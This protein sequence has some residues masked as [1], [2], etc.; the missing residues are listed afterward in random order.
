MH[1]EFINILPREPDK[2]KPFY[3]S[4]K[5]RLDSFTKD[6]E[7]GKYALSKINDASQR[8]HQINM[9]GTMFLRL[10]LITYNPSQ[11][12]TITKQFIAS[13]LHKVSVDDKGRNKNSSYKCITNFY[14]NVFKNCFPRNYK[15]P[16]SKGLHNTI[17]Y[18]ATDIL[19]NYQQNVKSNFISYAHEYVD[20]LLGFTQYIKDN[21]DQLSE[22]NK[23]YWKKIKTGIVNDL[24]KMSPGELE[25]DEKYHEWIRRHRS[26]I[27][28]ESYNK[29]HQKEA[30]VKGLQSCETINQ[31]L[32]KV[33]MKFFPCLLIMKQEFESSEKKGKQKNPCPQ[34]NSW[35][36]NNI[37]LD[38]STLCQLVYSQNN[39]NFPSQN[40]IKN[41]TKHYGDWLWSLYFQTEKYP[42]RRTY[43]DNTKNKQTNPYNR[44]G[45]MKDYQFCNQLKTDGVSASL[46][47]ERLDFHLLSK[48]KYEC[49]SNTVQ[50]KQCERYA[51]TSDKLC[52]V[53]GFRQEG[54]ELYTEQMT[55]DDISKE[56][57]VSDPGGN[58]LHYMKMGDTYIRYTAQQ[59]KYES[60]ELRYKQI[61]KRIYEEKPL[62]KS[63]STANDLEREK[64]QGT[65]SQ[66]TNPEK[67]KEYIKNKLLVHQ[68]LAEFYNKQIF[69]KLRLQSY[70]KTRQSE[71]MFVRNIQKNFGQPNEVAIHVGDWGKINKQ[72]KGTPPVPGI[73]LR[74]VFR[75]YGYSVYLIQEKYTSQTC[76]KCKKRENH[77]PFKRPHPHP[78][79]RKEGKTKKVHGLLQCKACG[80][81]WN[82]NK[83]AVLNITENVKENRPGSVP[84]SLSYS[85]C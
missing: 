50:E 80:T 73:R 20:T 35:I 65:N 5:E 19:Q 67:Y 53:H 84:H 43:L 76:Y 40:E 62:R 42:F 48:E 47:Y 38:T 74:R 31:A 30:S 57:V 78:K 1:Q 82:R 28:P 85:T 9:L 6:N 17:Q 27:L 52:D 33:P 7:L 56:D 37:T 61:R 44:N 29:M 24:L 8:M 32:E 55:P 14:N 34:I 51:I 11:I 60:G 46:L 36:P 71:K 23:K 72:M 10:Y 21:K 75:N 12:G 22:P 70:R 83:N 15:K 49:E 58:D 2:N 79:K 4:Y 26:K 3:T 66:T 16:S 41:N 54:K 25:S 18:S 59:R 68:D 13:I 63:N 77:N 45:E 39:K 81:F 64:L 69:R